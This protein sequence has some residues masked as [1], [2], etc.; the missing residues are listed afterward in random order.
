MKRFYLPKLTI[1]TALLS[2]NC[3][4]ANAQTVTFSTPSNS[5][6]TYSVPPGVTS[7]TVD[8]QGSQGGNAGASYGNGGMGGRVVATLAVTGGQVLNIYVGGQGAALAGTCCTSTAAGG[9]GGAQGGASGAYYY[10]A[11]GGGSSEIRIGG[12]AITNRV[13]V[14]GGGGGGGS[15]DC[16]GATSGGELG[17]AGGSATGAT[18]QICGSTTW[19]SCYNATG[20]SQ[21]TGGYAP[22]NGAYGTQTS[23]SNGVYYAGGGGGGY[24]GG[25]GGYYYSGGGGGSS[26]PTAAGTVAGVVVTNFT[27][28]QG[29]RTGNGIVTI[30]SPNVGSILGNSPVCIGSTFTLSSTGSGGTWS[31]SATGTATINSTSG[32]VT[33]VASGTATITYSANV[34]GCGS[35]FITT[36]V[37]VNPAP[38]PIS[39]TPN[40]CPGTTTS[41][42]D[43]G[44]GTWV[45]SN[46]SVAT[47]GSSSGTVSGIIA[48][49]ITITYTLPVTGCTAT[50]PIVVNP[51]PAPIAGT[52]VA[53][54]AGGTTS[55]SDPTPGGTWNSSTTSVALVSGTGLVTG[56]T[57]GNTNI[58]YTL[59]TGCMISQIVTINPLPSAISGTTSVCAGLTIT[60]S[61]AG[62]G[63]WSSSNSSLAVVGATTGIVTGVAAGTPSI[64][65]TLPTGCSISAAVVVN[66]IPA[67]ITGIASMCAGGTTTLSDATLGGTWSSNN[68]SIA[69]IVP[70]TGVVSGI[71]FGSANISYTLGTTCFIT[72]P[73]AVTPLP[74]IY[75]VT[76]GGGYC[77]GSTGTHVGLSFANSGVNYKLYNGG[78]LVATVAGS[79]AGLDFGLI[80][81]TGTYTVIAVNATTGCTSNMSGSATVSINPLPNVYNVTGGGNYC[82]G[83]PGVHILLSGSDAGVNYQIYLGGVP[84]GSPIAGTGTGLDFGF[85]SAPGT[86]TVVAS[87]AGTGCSINMSGSAAIAINPLPTV[88]NLSAGGGYCVGGTGLDIVLSGSEAGVNYQLYYGGTAMGSPMPGTGLALHYG[89]HTG[90]GIYTVSG[91][92]TVTGCSSNMSG[93]TTIAVNPLPNIYNV[94]GGGSYCAGGTGVHV[95]LNFSNT[96]VNYQLYRSGIPVGSLVAG[97][98]AGLDFGLQTVAGTYTVVATDATTLCTNNMSGS[99]VIST[100]ALPN[101]FTVSG[102]GSYCTGGT[103]VHISLSGSNTG[104]HYQ[105]FN[106]GVPVGTAV[107]GTGSP[108]DFGLKTATGIYT[109]TA[110]NISTSCANNMTG[111]ATIAINSLPAAYTVTG[112]GTSF[113]AGGTGIEILLSGS[114][115]GISYQ[116]LK[117]VTV[118]GSPV[119]GTGSG[120]TFGFQTLTGT[121]TVIGTNTGTG[122]STNMT[123]STSVTSN[124]LPT[125]FTVTGGGGYCA[126]GL[127]V[128][129]GLSSSTV[130]VDYQLFG[131]ISG[132][133]GGPVPGIGSSIDFGYQSTADIYTVVATN[134]ITLCTKPMT[135]SA[136]VVI[137]TLP[138]AY[139]V[140][141]GGNYCLGGSGSDIGLDGSDAGTNYQLLFGTSPSGSLVGGGGT[142]IDFGNRAG[143]GTYTVKATD[144][145][146]GCTAIMSGSAMVGTNPLPAAYTVTGGGT[147]CVPGGSGVN[148]NLN[149]SDI[150]I[151]YQLYFNGSL[152]TSVL[153]LS[154]IGGS[155]AF[156]PQTGV[157]IYNVV[158]TDATT[159]CS[160]NM[161]G[162]VSINTNPAPTVETMT[163]GGGYC[164]GGTGRTVGITGS[165]AGIHY[166]LYYS[167]LAIGSTVTGTGTAM[168]FG[169]YTSA[170]NYTVVAS[171]GGTCAT[172]MLGAAVISI[173]PLPTAFTLSAS[174]G[175]IF[176]AGSAGVDVSLSSSQNGVNYQLKRGPTSIGGL[177]PGSDSAVDFGFQNVAGTYTS[178]ATDTTTGCTSSMSGS[179]VISSIPLPVVHNVTGGGAYCA[180]GTGVHV[181]LDGSNTNV[182]Y[183]LYFGV[184]ASGTPMAGTGTL[185]DFGAMTAA[186]NY[187]VKATDAATSCMKTMADTAVVSVNPLL[188]PGVTIGGH[189]TIVKGQR[190]TLTATATTAGTN[191]MYQWYVNGYQF[192]GATAIRF[193]SNKFVDLDSVSCEVTSNGGPCAGYTHAVGVRIHVGSNVGVQTITA[194]DINVNVVPNP[195]KG[196]FNVTG[197][198]GSNDDAEVTYEVTDLLGHVVYTNK[199]IA[200]GGNIEERIQISNVAN[201][202]YILSLKTESERKV[203]HVVIAQ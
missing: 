146:T 9:V 54:A 51:L 24:W 43:A 87:I 8:V 98:N 84:S 150:G 90:A 132:P 56:V 159:L 109:V 163:G 31:S 71:T 179:A 155:L 198:L 61:D 63:T 190:D 164:V 139:N 134:S 92:N 143:A 75:N 147:Y 23:G 116:L 73:V 72:I 112:A 113:C 78:S 69:T 183:Q 12:T 1:L 30:C 33:G 192:P 16:T 187:T 103:G 20:G 60:L 161:T 168:M 177:M 81:A 148:V 141:G 7:V 5:P 128:H 171:P 197:S 170:G 193:I 135:G 130:G 39:G 17:G 88:F 165:D 106:G 166:Q 110:T 136:T 194:S 70:T 4:S 189:T 37:T 203:L 58:T 145:I 59:P 133:V 15:E 174:G 111:S 138:N 101:T 173:N 50:L 167:G 195:N 45:S 156:G 184:T 3:V 36:I 122:C 66:A 124:P 152:L 119:I 125:A 52:A 46:T 158:A 107:N 25:G 64:I 142:A 79:N 80:T 62:G 196:V 126:G 151:S 93:S 14:A 41:L 44:G 180:G 172:N 144:P 153:P 35:G 13:I 76:G 74:T 49:S 160:S 28:T 199:S 104:I 102:G 201:G 22:C 105:L 29:Y 188:T 89:L 47:I 108:I 6:V 19:C 40:L 118:M 169:T 77:I 202:M 57:A 186:G 42:S 82:P 21:T 181:T 127:G 65:Y 182:N 176:C 68:L 100:T 53:C 99:V 96:G 121:Y 91:V 178:V 10:G 95:G 200:K 185:L 123:G 97:S 55:L 34:A 94:T 67:A 27:S 137:N 140:T 157:G 129:V 48:G 38:A 120:L 11:G 131:L 26:Y 191:P 32:V 114:D 162:T 85:R 149:N 83:G 175:G 2:I 154:G 18:G 117:G 86:Y 115:A